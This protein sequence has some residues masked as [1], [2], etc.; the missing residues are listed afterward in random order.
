MTPDDTDDETL[1]QLE[2]LVTGDAVGVRTAKERFVIG[3]AVTPAKQPNDL[4]TITDA[5]TG[6]KV[7][8]LSPP[9]EEFGDPFVREKDGHMMVGM[10]DLAKRRGGGGFYHLGR[11]TAF[12]TGPVVAPRDL[13]EENPATFEVIL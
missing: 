5:R 10:V 6:E 3:R 1:G 2:R 8:D 4:F 13:V 7:G 11:V 12:K 9:P